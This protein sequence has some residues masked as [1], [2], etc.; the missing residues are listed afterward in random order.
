MVMAMPLDLV[1]LV[2]CLLRA[3]LRQLEGE[4]QHAVH[5]DARHHGLLDHDLAR[6]P[7]YMRPPMLE[8]SPSVFSRTIT[9]RSRPAGAAA[10]AAHHRANDAGHQ[11]RRA[12]VDVLVELAAKQQ[13]RAPQRHMVGNLL[14]PADGTEVDRLM[15]ADRS[16]QLSGSI[17]PCF[18]SSPSS[19]NRM[20][21]LQ[22]DAELAGGGIHHAQALG[23]DFLAD[24]VAGDGDVGT[25]VLEAM[26]GTTR[27]HITWLWG[28]P[29]NSSSGSPFPATR[30]WRR[31]PSRSTSKGLNVSSMAWIL[32][33]A[34]VCI[35]Q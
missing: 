3:R 4:L 10:V 1:A 22:V 34:G 29:C 23:H 9:C 16:F 18:S 5:A 17:L 35:K 32:R 8:Y 12:Q 7:S 26:R 2:R 24:A 6:V 28:W 15:A 25:V 33:W 14:G 20:V 21:E 11:A 27:C 31:T 19:K 30:P 13:Q